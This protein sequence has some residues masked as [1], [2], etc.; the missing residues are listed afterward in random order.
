MCD[1]LSLQYFELDTNTFYLLFIKFQKK[2]FKI[3][4]ANQHTHAEILI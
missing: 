3:K 1:F 4:N 2:K